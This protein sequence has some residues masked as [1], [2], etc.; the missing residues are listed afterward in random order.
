VLWELAKLVQLRRI[1]I[2]LYDR[3]VK[4]VLAQLHVW[5]IDLEIAR[6]ST[7]LDFRGDP[8]DEIIAATSI[9][10]DI[11]LLTRDHTILR[12]HIVPLATTER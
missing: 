2:D 4:H 1:D 8:A 11:P 12:S 9:I 5:P 7:N 6:A 3:D 10:H